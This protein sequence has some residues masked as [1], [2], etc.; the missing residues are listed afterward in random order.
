[1]NSTQIKIFNSLDEVANLKIKRTYRSE[2]N[3]SP[4]KMQPWLKKL[5]S[6]SHLESS[7]SEAATPEVFCKERCS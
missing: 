4:A 3:I 2:N 5:I 7:T 1:M 6:C